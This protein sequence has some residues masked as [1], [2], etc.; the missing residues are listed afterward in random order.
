MC[1]NRLDRHV[2]APKAAREGASRIAHPIT[3]KILRT[4]AKDDERPAAPAD[5]ADKP[6]FATP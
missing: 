5:D 2:S 6:T 1:E 3:D 4:L